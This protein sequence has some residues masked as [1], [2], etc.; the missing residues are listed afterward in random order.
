[1]SLDAMGAGLEEFRVSSPAEIVSLIKQLADGNVLV[2]LST[3]EGACYGST[4]WTLDPARGLICLSAEATDPQL[5]SL[6]ESSEVVAVS[7][8]DSVKV[9]FDLQDLVLVHSGHG[10]ALNARFPRELFRFQRRNSF[11]VKP[12][13]GTV[14][15]AKF[16]HPAQPGVQLALRV[17]DVSIG[18]LALF[19]PNEQPAVEPGVRLERV[20]IELDG[21]TRLV[22]DVVVHHVTLL[23][24]E[25]KGVRLGCEMVN[26]SG[27]GSRSLQRYIDQTQ[28]RRRLLAL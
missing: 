1:M 6:L 8:L 21:D 18:G 9:Q 17:L 10:S 28:K 14:P 25:S 24:H 20:H 23:N 4:I 11:R 2:N 26:L 12:L 15:T 22:T 7:Y 19:L 5:Q 3:P 16:A 27:D 13:L